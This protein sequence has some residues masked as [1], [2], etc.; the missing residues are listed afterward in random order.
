MDHIVQRLRCTLL[1]HERCTQPSDEPPSSGYLSRGSGGFFQLPPYHLH[2]IVLS[3]HWGLNPGPS[4]Y[5]TDALPLSYRGLLCTSALWTSAL[6]T[7]T[8]QPSHGLPSAGSRHTKYDGPIWQDTI[9]GHRVHSVVVSHPHSKQDREKRDR[10]EKAKGG[11]GER[12]E[13]A[14]AGRRPPAAK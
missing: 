12:R 13:G 11:E 3:P 6:Q 10:E 8:L 14:P 5:K 1:S 7:Q 9:H 4:V 2:C